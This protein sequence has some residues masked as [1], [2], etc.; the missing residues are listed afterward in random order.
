[1]EDDQDKAGRSLILLGRQGWPYVG[2][3]AHGW[4]VGRGRH[5]DQ[6]RL[7]TGMGEEHR[8]LHRARCFGW[9]KHYS[10]RGGGT[11]AGVGEKVRWKR[12][13][14]RDYKKRM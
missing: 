9:S 8:G 1:M 2:G 5:A 12:R 3:K 13:L 14:G 6:A 10:K 4:K 7:K 11:W